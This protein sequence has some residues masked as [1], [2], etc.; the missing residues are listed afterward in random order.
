[1]VL[2]EEQAPSQRKF[3][4]KIVLRKPSL[5]TVFATAPIGQENEIAATQRKLGVYRVFKGT[6]TNIMGSSVPCTTM[7]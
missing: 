6:I 3:A 5:G 1:M 7:V 4:D 2:T